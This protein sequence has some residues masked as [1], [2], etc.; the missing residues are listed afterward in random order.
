M[1]SSR[2]FAY[3]NALSKKMDRLAKARGR[4]WT[5]VDD[6]PKKEAAAFRRIKKALE[7]E[8]PM[9]RRKGSKRR[10][11]KRKSI[12]SRTKRNGGFPGRWGGKHNYYGVKQRNGSLWWGNQS[13]DP[14]YFKEDWGDKSRRTRWVSKAEAKKHAKKV[15]GEVWQLFNYFAP[16]K[17]S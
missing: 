8:N 10:S 7:R 15:D 11:Y 2:E 16:K 17:V 12:R 13:N 9:K 4:S 3:Y 14:H 6:L 5:S 1:I